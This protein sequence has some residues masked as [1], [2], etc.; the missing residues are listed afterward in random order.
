MEHGSDL[1]TFHDAISIA[2]EVVEVRV[3]YS[4]SWAL[5]EKPPILQLLKNFPAFY[6]TRRFITVFT[7]ALHWSRS[8]A[9]SIQSIPS[10]PI[11][12][13]SILILSTHLRLGLPS[14]LFPSGPYVIWNK[15]IRNYVYRSEGQR[16]PVSSYSN[17][18]SWVPWDLE[19]IF[20]KKEIGDFVLQYTDSGWDSGI[21]FCEE[22]NEHS[23]SLKRR[24]ISRSAEPLLVYQ[25]LLCPTYVISR[26][27]PYFCRPATDVFIRGMHEHAIAKSLMNTPGLARSSHR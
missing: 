3:T 17:I 11:P 1:C 10:H 9:R 25:L 12:L 26:F 18:W 15:L 6:G 5:L 8:W 20:T 27:I 13:R 16:H 21:T 4:W 24:G 14:G 19:P 2:V 23:N 7:R 22:G